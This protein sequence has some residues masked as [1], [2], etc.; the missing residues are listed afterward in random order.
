LVLTDSTDSIAAKYPG[1]FLAATD[2]VI[3]FTVT[4]S[5]CD[6]HDAYEATA[7]LQVPAGTPPGEYYIV[8]INYPKRDWG[9]C[10]ADCNASYADVAGIAPTVMVVP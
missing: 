8:S 3:T 4:Q 6:L 1:L 9:T 2:G 7:P 5:G 10:P